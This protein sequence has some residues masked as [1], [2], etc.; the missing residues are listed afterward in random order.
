MVRVGVSTGS[1]PLTGAVERYTAVD[2]D[3]DDETPG[4]YPM[5]FEHGVLTRPGHPSSGWRVERDATRA[6]RDEQAFTV[7]AAV[8]DAAR[9][10]LALGIAPTGGPLATA[11]PGRLS[12]ELGDD[13]WTWP[14]ASAP[15]AAVAVLQAARAIE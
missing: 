7:A 10:F 12:L 13:V 4:V 9:G 5:L 1:G 8:Y 11:M 6:W 2:I 3:A 14:V 15:A